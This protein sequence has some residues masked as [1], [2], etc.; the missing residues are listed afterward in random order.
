[1]GGTFVGTERPAGRGV[2]LPA[3]T[4]RFDDVPD[5]GAAGSGNSTLPAAIAWSLAPGRS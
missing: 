4:L 2:A 1:M 3:L 5:L